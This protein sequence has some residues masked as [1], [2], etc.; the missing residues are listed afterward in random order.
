MVKSVDI[1]V[2]VNIIIKIMNIA[3]IHL[4]NATVVPVGHTKELLQMK[5]LKQDRR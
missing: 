5:H 2:D 1:K 4:Q 3:A